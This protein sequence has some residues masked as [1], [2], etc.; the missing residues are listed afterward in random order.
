M[1]A[2]TGRFRV[3]SV[4]SLPRR[5]YS[6]G[7]IPKRARQG[8]VFHEEVSLQSPVSAGRFHCERPCSAGGTG[9]SFSTIRGLSWPTSWR[10]SWWAA[11]AGM[12]FDFLAFPYALPSSYLDKGL[13]GGRSEATGVTAQPDF[14]I[15]TGVTCRPFCAALLAVAPLLSRLLSS[16]CALGL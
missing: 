5:I 13:A 11:I 12:A 9:F 14:P 2:V 1:I 15:A 7:V 8:A 6:G 10:W 16:P 3:R 4:S